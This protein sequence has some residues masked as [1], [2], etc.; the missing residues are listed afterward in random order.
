MNLKIFLTTIHYE[1]EFFRNHTFLA[2]IVA[3]CVLAGSI[4]FCYMMLFYFQ[5]GECIEN[6]LREINDLRDGINVGNYNGNRY[7]CTEYISEI[8]TEYHQ[9]MTRIINEVVPNHKE[10]VEVRFLKSDMFNAF[11]NIKLIK[12]LNIDKKMTDEQY[13]YHTAA[14]GDAQTEILRIYILSFECY[15]SMIQKQSFDRYKTQNLVETKYPEILQCISNYIIRERLLVTD[16]RKYVNVISFSKKRFEDSYAKYLND[17]LYILRKNAG[18]FT[19]DAIFKNFPTFRECFV[20][21]SEN[22]QFMEKIMFV[23]F[24]NTIGFNKDE[25]EVEYKDITD[26]IKLLTNHLYEYCL[27]NKVVKSERSIYADDVD[28]LLSDGN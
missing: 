4:N 12:T 6:Y 15:N 5:K 20:K 13:G 3:L 24:A 17:D 2:I 7:K 22:L 1:K 23:D 19:G 27:S 10:C 16:I 8:K 28:T 9:T 18:I 14:L 26:R 21:K 11:L 25:M